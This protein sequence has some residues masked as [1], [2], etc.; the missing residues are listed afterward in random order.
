MKQLAG[1][2]HMENDCFLRTL[3]FEMKL[4]VDMNDLLGLRWG[5]KTMRFKSSTVR[6]CGTWSSGTWS[7]QRPQMSWKKRW[8]NNVYG[9]LTTLTMRV[10]VRRP[11]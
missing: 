6:S 3:K 7:S 2:K 4:S 1:G 5:G 10:V 11:K 9:N 8:C